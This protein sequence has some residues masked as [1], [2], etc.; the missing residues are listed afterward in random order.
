[1]GGIGLP[2]QPIAAACP[3]GREGRGMRV[4][5]FAHVAA[6]SEL[7]RAEFYAQDWRI[8]EELGHEVYWARTIRDVRRGTD[9]I[10][11]WWWTYAWQAIAAAR[12]RR[13][14]VVTTGVFDLTKF[15]QRPWYQRALM[16][17]GARHSDANIFVSELERAGIS[18]LLGLRD[19]VYSPC[20][21]DTA[22][23]GEQPRPQRAQDE[24]RLIANVAWKRATNMRRKM[25]PE[26]VESITWVSKED[27]RARLLLAGP[28]E[29]GEVELRALVRRLGLDDVVSF[30]GQISREEKVELMQTCDVYPQVSTYE[31]FG[32][33]IAEA[34]ACGA[35][36][37]VSRAGA[38][39]EV[40]GDCGRYV[41]DLTPRAIADAL[42]EL[43]AD[44]AARRELGARGAERI[45]TLFSVERR[46]RDIAEVIARVA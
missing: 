21:I 3:V 42:L 46:K 45:R 24:T 32:L 22:V 23:Y 5:F 20:V 2:V 9:L 41:A 37:V 11:C 6:E 31:G 10:F 13:C 38:V 35:P 19:A 4:C 7:R 34:M 12:L 39:P 40:V 29:D 43:L 44:D 8:L 27:P 15:P 33:A 17:W 18:Q 36:V 30:R 16:A 26:L 14:P 25:L 28:P 1:M